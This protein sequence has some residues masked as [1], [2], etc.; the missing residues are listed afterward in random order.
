MSSY[1][2]NS[3]SHVSESW[4][5]G[6]YLGFGLPP[7]IL[8]WIPSQALALQGF[9]CCIWFVTCNICHINNYFKK[10]K[11][12]IINFEHFILIGFSKL[13]RDF[14]AFRIFILGWIGPFNA[15]HLL[16]IGL[17]CVN[18]CGYNSSKKIK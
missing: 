1:D 12:L 9:S 8:C 16:F 17:W 18:R 14:R 11:Y 10:Y 3:L 4:A 6:P 2:S 15:L 13:F 5:L 7:D